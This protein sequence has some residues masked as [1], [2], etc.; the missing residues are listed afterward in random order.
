MDG[1]HSLDLVFALRAVVAAIFGLAVGFVGN[2][3]GVGGGRPRLLLVY[4]A[5]RIR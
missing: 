5:A 2:M 1:M 4:W 3:V